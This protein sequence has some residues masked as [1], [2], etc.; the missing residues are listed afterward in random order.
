MSK[1]P[2]AN[3]VAVFDDP[4]AAE[5]A[6]QVLHEDGFGDD[7]V[8]I[9]PLVDRVVVTVQADGQSAEASASLAGGGA[10][11]VQTVAR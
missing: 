10:S 2:Q 4:V 8:N 7:K 9:R 3:V 11:G 6:V 5:V 1:I